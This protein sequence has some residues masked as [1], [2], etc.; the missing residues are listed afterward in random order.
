MYDFKFCYFAFCLI[1]YFLRTGEVDLCYLATV[2]TVLD[3]FLYVITTS[4]KRRLVE[5][6]GNWVNFF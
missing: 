5:K 4:C 1:G 3:L 6:L 2:L